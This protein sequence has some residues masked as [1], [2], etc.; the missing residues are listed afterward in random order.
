[1]LVHYGTTVVLA[2]TSTN[3]WICLR[4][5]DEETCNRRLALALLLTKSGTNRMMLD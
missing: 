3:L 1:M 2:S 5:I 4:K